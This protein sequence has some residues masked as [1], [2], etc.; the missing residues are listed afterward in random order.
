MVKIKADK[1]HKFTKPKGKRV[2]ELLRAGKSLREIAALGNMPSASTIQRW[3]DNNPEFAKDWTEAV[4]ARDAEKAN[5]PRKRSKP[6]RVEPMPARKAPS[7][8]L[9]EYSEEIADKICE[10]IL[11]G[12][13]LRRVCEDELFPDRRTVFK[14]SLKHPSFKRKLDE[15]QAF[16]VS[17]LVDE[18]HE[19]ADDGRNDFME[20]LKKDGS[21]SYV[22]NPENVAR[23]KLRITWRQWMAQNRIPEIYGAKVQQQITGANGGPLEATVTHRRQDD[24]DRLELGRRIMFALRLAQKA[25]EAVLKEQQEGIADTQPPP[26]ETANES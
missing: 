23:S 10:R 3:R 14:W 7:G 25:G 8:T 11:Y 1:R 26:E 9:S 13:T 15:A 5:T 20:Q 2:C 12:D 4:K 18:M 24:L 19:I 16:A 6:Q 17:M 22:F 21:I